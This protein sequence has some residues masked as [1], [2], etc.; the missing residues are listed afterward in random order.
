MVNIK[1]ILGDVEEPIDATKENSTADNIPKKYWQQIA[2]QPITNNNGPV[3][4][5]LMRISQIENKMD[6]N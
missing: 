2:V 6:K 1:S 3:N 4:T 5:I